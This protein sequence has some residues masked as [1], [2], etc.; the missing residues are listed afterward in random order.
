ETEH[1]DHFFEHE[2]DLFD[3]PA[4]ALARRRLAQ[5][6]LG[7]LRGTR[8]GTLLSVGA[9]D[10]WLELELAPRFD[11][12]VAIEISPKAVRIAR[13]RAR[14]AGVS[15]V[16]FRVGDAESLPM[17]DGSVDVVLAS[18]VLHH[19]GDD[20]EIRLVLERAGWWLRSGGVALSA[21]PSSRRAIGV[22]QR[23][24]QG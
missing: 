9:G 16:E 10:G 1:H 2:A 5:V 6:V 18:H 7:A 15:N 17:P 12:V 21:D 20:N 22:L 24:V 11:K 14:G 4:F 13:A 19:V 3:T 8:R 23:L